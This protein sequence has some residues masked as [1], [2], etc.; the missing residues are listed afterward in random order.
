MIRHLFSPVRGAF[1]GGREQ[2]MLQAD[3][4]GRLGGR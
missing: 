3:L 2:T 4:A 1:P